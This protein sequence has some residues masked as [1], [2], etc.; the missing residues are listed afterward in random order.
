MLWLVLCLC[1]T[2]E[3]KFM[4]AS[5]AFAA[6]KTILND[7]EYDELKNELKAKGS[8]VTAQVQP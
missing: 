2:T 3:S 5:K 4:Q 6:G 1:S 7:Q 8:K